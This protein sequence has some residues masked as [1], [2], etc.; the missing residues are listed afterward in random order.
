MEALDIRL[1]LLN[2]YLEI[3]YLFAELHP[4]EIDD[5]VVY[6]DIP[7]RIG[8][9]PGLDVLNDFTDLV[10]DVAELIHAISRSL[11]MPIFGQFIIVLI[12]G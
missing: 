3:P 5:L 1:A 8:V 6:F 2:G 12:I 4:L 10:V 9:A 11:F 7:L